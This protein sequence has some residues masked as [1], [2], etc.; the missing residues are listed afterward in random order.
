M[1]VFKHK[2]TPDFSTGV[3]RKLLKLVRDRFLKINSGRLDR[4]REAMSFRQRDMLEVL[5]LLYHVN[6]PL[7]PGYVSQ[8]TPKGI[9]AYVPEKSTLS[10]AKSFSQTFRFAS[11]KRHK[12][13]VYSLFMMGSTGTLAHSESSDVDLWLC[14]DPQLDPEQIN[15]LKAKAAKLDDWAN[16]HGLELHTFLMNADGFKQGQAVPEMDSESSGSAQHYLLLDEFYRTAILLE[17][18]YPLWWLIP[19]ELEVDYDSHTSML[20]HKRFIKSTD[21]IDFGSALHIPKSEL[22]GAGL[23]QL[24]KSLDS[25]YKSVLKLMLAEVYAQEL[26]SKPSLS[27]VFK[28]AVYDD[29]LALDSLDPYLLIYRRL[30]DYL[31]GQ[32]DEKRLDLVR[33][34]FYLKVNKKL[35]RRPNSGSVSWQRNVLQA[36]LSDWSWSEYQLRLL[37]ERASWKVDQVIIERQELLSELTN[38]YRFL[39]TYARAN[40]ISSSITTEDLSLLGRKLYATFQRKAGKVEK[41]NPGI[42]PNIWEEN[43]AIHHSSSQPFQADKKA[44]LLYRDLASTD[45]AS[46]HQNLRKSSNL[47]ELIAWLFFN[48]IVSGS[49]RLSLLPGDSH[50]TVNEVRSIIRAL[51]QQISMP[52]PSVPQTQFLTPAG[53]KHIVLFVN[54]GVDPMMELSEQG[55]HRLSDRTD[56]LGYSSQR[57]N[58]VKTID[59]VVLNSWHEMSAHRYEKGETLMQNLHAY[60]HVCAE[61]L[62]AAQFELSVHCFTSQRADAIANRVKVL[63][64]DARKV[65][66]SGLRINAVRYVI[67]VEER[68]YLLQRIGGQFRSQVIQTDAL[69]YDALS[70]GG[71]EHSQIVLDRYALQGD[72]LLA[73]ALKQSKAQKIQIFYLLENECIQVCV[74]DELGSLLR[75][76]LSLVDESEFQ[77]S[78]VRFMSTVIERRQLN[79][80]LLATESLPSIEIYK[81]RSPSQATEVKVQQVRV[82]PERSCHALVATAFYD[83][84]DIQFDLSFDGKEFSFAEHDNR[85]LEALAHYINHHPTLDKSLPVNVCDISYPSNPMLMRSTVESSHNTLDYLRLYQQINAALKALLD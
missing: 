29:E 46:F 57:Y 54:V 31:K 59:Q 18:R 5:P 17:G 81:A 55:M 43:L 56:S 70:K 3:D 25:P 47:I 69:L 52:L 82:I 10:I 85:Q 66:F 71:S 83:G 20:L 4:A 1:A 76:E 79:H 68:F 48:G 2:V 12:A 84:I 21:V 75:F 38:S 45:D 63:F 62:D 26:P 80:S 9:S 24:Y 53:I 22:V 11:D 74:L 34:S 8:D 40:N 36:L 41:V 44:W 61:Q 72:R 14:H 60:L 13:S 37:D 16:G 35:S 23:W 78:L 51:E 27:V 50:V 32:N 64:N 67:E 39:S 15:L 58:L 6:H 28:Q 30:E 7:L 77:S 49:T 19:P 33:K 42:A 73:A 65:F